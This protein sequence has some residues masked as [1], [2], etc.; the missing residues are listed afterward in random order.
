MTGIGSAGLLKVAQAAEFLQVSVR[1]VQRQIADG[2][3]AVVRIGRNV[4]IERKSL[5]ILIKRSTW[6]EHRE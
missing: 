3:L 1:T 6:H 2:H 5:E 4:R